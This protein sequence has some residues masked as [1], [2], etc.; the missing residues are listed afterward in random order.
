[1]RGTAFFLVLTMGAMMAQAQTA[2]KPATGAKTAVH[3]AAT[4]AAT[5]PP[6]VPPV[7]AVTKTAF[8]LRYQDIKIGTGEEAQPNWVYRVHYTGWLAAD[9]HKF[10]SSYDH[11]RQP[12]MD[13]DGKPVMG[14]DGKPKL[15]DAEPIAFPQGYGRVIPGFDQGFAGMHVGGKRRLFIPWQL[16]YGAKGRPGPD[17][18]HP[19]IPP[20]ADL[21]FD[22]ELVDQKEMQMPMGHPGMMGGGMPG[23]PGAPMPPGHPPVTPGTA[24]PAQPAAPAEPAKPATPPNPAQPQ[25]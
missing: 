17:A 11:P 13:K 10:D 25:Q 2:A 6:G 12:A 1:M 9:G 16:A 20:K 8:A 22:V 5:L 19:G 23:H 21:I 15:G 3:H 14:E 7:H 4:A 18:A 24:Q